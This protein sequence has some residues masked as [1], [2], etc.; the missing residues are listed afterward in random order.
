MRF[1]RLNFPHP[2]QK[3]KNIYNEYN[4]NV[5]SKHCCV[6]VHCQR[7]YENM[8]MCFSDKSNKK[9]RNLETKC[10]IGDFNPISFKTALRRSF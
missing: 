2:I 9:L 8:G 1:R 4:S 3:L 5:T 7:Y 6:C 10:D